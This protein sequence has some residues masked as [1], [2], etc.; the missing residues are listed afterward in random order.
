MDLLKVRE[1][2]INYNEDL[3]HKFMDFIAEDDSISEEKKKDYLEKL[4]FF[5]V[6]YLIDFESELD[7]DPENEDGGIITLDTVSW[8]YIDSFLGRWYIQKTDKATEQSIKDYQEA[9]LAFYDYL[10]RHKMY[11]ESSPTYNKMKRRFGSKRKY[12][13]RFNSY[14]EIQ[15]IKDK[16]EEEYLEQMREWEFE[17]LY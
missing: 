9:F 14:M 17:D 4:E 16:D 2:W 10:K 3:I 12:K 8:P 1:K 13:K 11:K 7:E 5:S 6:N 15:D